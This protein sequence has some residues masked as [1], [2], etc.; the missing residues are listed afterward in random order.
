MSG[1]SI[2]VSEANTWRYNY[3]LFLIHRFIL[4]RST[5]LCLLC[6]FTHSWTK[7]HGTQVDCVGEIVRP[8]QSQSNTRE[9]KYFRDKSFAFF[10]FVLREYLFAWKWMYTVHCTVYSCTHGHRTIRS[11][12]LILFYRTFLFTSRSADECHQ[13]NRIYENPRKIE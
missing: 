6:F 4:G 10:L 8:N 13:T 11:L 3:I 9:A 7:T 1:V 5:H 2:M 12:F